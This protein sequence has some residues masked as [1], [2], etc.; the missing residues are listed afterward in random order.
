MYR[1]SFLILLKELY[2]HHVLNIHQEHPLCTILSTFSMLSFAYR[3]HFHSFSFSLFGFF[4]FFVTCSWQRC[5]PS[6][7]CRPPI[8]IINAP[9]ATKTCPRW[10]S[11]SLCQRPVKLPYCTRSTKAKY[12]KKKEEKPKILK[13][14]KKKHTQTTSSCLDDVVDWDCTLVP[15]PQPENQFSFI[16]GPK[17]G[18][19]LPT[20]LWLCFASAL[21]LNSLSK[22]RSAYNKLLSSDKRVAN[23]GVTARFSSFFFLCSQYCLPRPRKGHAQETAV[24]RLHLSSR[25][26]KK[27]KKK[28]RSLSDW[29]TLWWV[30]SD[31]SVAFLPAW[32]MISN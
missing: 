6:C 26:K 28:T 8:N 30:A 11:I 23:F 13:A 4:V 14:L 19:C 27:K 32:W 1:R 9:N 5:L 2:L 16:P 10:A 22:S 12:T 3:P 31:A 20:R 29:M 18:F 25:T 7:S 15:H 21:R 24:R 17:T